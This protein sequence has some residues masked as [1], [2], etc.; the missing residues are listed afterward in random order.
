MAKNK[1]YLP[2]LSLLV[3]FNTAHADQMF[4]GI[5]L[6]NQ[7]LT[8]EL[9]VI[10]PASTTTTKDTGSGLG[11]YI[12]YFYKSRYRFNATLSHINYDAASLTSLTASA[13]YLFPFGSGFTL[14]TGVTAG[15]ATIKFS[16]GSVS[17]MSFGTLYGV[18]AGGIAFLSDSVM[19]ELGY[20]FRPANIETDIL[21][22]V[23][24]ATIATSTIDELSETYIN[25][26]L[27]F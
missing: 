10:S 6:I 27:I 18:Q 9:N 22:P 2:A 4:Y 19:I 17:D 23:T 16:D 1:R 24:K 15:G 13:D 14:F 25:L 7:Q 11:L 3:F 5:A 20:R 26:I 8:Q 12:D 21:D